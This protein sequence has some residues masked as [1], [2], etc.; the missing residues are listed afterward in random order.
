MKRIQQGIALLLLIGTVCLLSSCG[1]LALVGSRLAAAE[2]KD[3]HHSFGAWSVKRE[4]TCTETG[5][6]K[7]VCA[8]C[9]ESE[10]ETLPVTGHTEVID[11][12][13]DPTC[14]QAGKSQGSH[15]AECGTVLTEQTEIPMPGY[16]ATEIND[17]AIRYVG[18]IITYNKAGTALSLGTGVVY[19]SDGMILTN[20]HVI[21]GA[22]SAKITINGASHT[23]RNVLAYDKDIDLAVLQIRGSDFE[24][25]T[26]CSEA[27]PVGS[28]VYAVG[29]SK[30]LTN[31]FSQ[32][33]VTYYDRVIDNVRY[34]QHDASITNGN[35]GGP[36][37][38]EYGE[39]IGINTWGVADSQNLNFAVFVAE[40]RRLDFDTPMTMA[41][42]YR[43][44]YSPEEILLNW[45]L[46]NIDYE[47]DTV[48]R[49]D[50]VVED[51]FYSICY[52]VQTDI[53][54]VD[55]LWSFD[56]GTEMY[57]MVNLTD[58]DEEHLFYADYYQGNTT[59]HQSN[60]IL[61]GSSFTETSPLLYTES[62]G[63][64]PDDAG[65]TE[66]YQLGICDLLS[67]FEWYMD[68]YSVGVSLADFGFTAYE[69]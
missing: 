1:A 66:V 35:S 15:C 12:E 9:E 68:G 39:V 32:G 25:A 26:L 4:A 54:F 13:T 38:N 58:D 51:T 18:E 47:D 45:L 8:L 65:L 23:V 7:R 6:R 43:A 27:V 40:L 16:T 63:L 46:Q 37:I 21:E 55:V 50:Y 60:G 69:A 5:I 28:K 10:E 61:I 31:T 17:Q 49:A 20:Y 48:I 2:E 59:L 44:S 62:D 52:G 34:L 56:D 53:L 19:S 24:H 3:C 30:G 42:F 22:Y 67:W 11:E 64:D 41:E 29:S 14:L 57:L 33:I 36:L